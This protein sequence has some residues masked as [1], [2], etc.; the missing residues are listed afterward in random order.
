M[1]G[2]SALIYSDSYMGYNFSPWHPMKPV[3]LQLTAELIK[4]YGLPELPQ[5]RIV[6]PRLASD[7]ELALVHDP[8]YIEKVRELS[9]PDLKQDYAPGWGLGT[10]DNPVFPGMHEASATIAGGA[11]AAAGMIMDG[12]LDHALHMGGGLHHARR[13]RASGFC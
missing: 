12:E 5:L 13:A 3:R 6:E 9:A 7:E 1:P 8:A 11:L 10:G 2:L 4:A